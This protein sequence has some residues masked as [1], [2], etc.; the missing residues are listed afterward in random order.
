MKVYQ[1]AG[2]GCLP[3]TVNRD[4][5]PVAI[6]FDWRLSDVY[7]ISTVRQVTKGVEFVMAQADVL[8]TNRCTCDYRTARCP[9]CGQVQEQHQGFLGFVL[10][11]VVFVSRT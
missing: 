11:N 10:S 6:I 8:M 3:S 4:R 1:P 5:K 2:S 7:L 9:E